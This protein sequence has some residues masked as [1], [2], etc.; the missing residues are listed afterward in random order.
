M[1]RL[2]EPALAEATCKQHFNHRDEKDSEHGNRAGH[3]RV[4][5]VPEWRK[6]AV[7]EGDE[8]SREEVYEGSS[9]ENAST[10]VTGAEKKGGGDA[11]A[12]ELFG[13]DWECTCWGGFCQ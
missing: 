8:G 2:R 1:V 4:L 3:G 6:T 13:N 11:E 7:G 9:N 10:E 5:P 12:G